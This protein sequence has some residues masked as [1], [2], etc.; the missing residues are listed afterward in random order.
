MKPLSEETE[1]RIQEMGKRLLEAARERKQAFWAREH[2]EEILFHK[3]MD[4]EQLRAQLLRFVDVLPALTSDEDLSKHLHEYLGEEDLPIPGF[5]KWG[6]EHSRGSVAAHLAAGAVRTA[7]HGLAKRFIGGESVNDA[8]NTVKHLR[9]ENMC[10]TLDLLGEATVSEAEADEY[11]D[12]Y[13]NFIKDLAPKLKAW[14]ANPLMDE[15]NGR[16]CPRFNLSIKVSSLCSQIDPIDIEGRAETIKKRLR[17]I[18]QAAKK[19]GAF[20][21]LDMEQYDMKE[22]ILRVFQDILVEP[23]FRDWPDVGIA[24][25]AYLRDTEKDLLGLIDWCR[26][27]GT[28]VTVRLVRGAYWDY[29]KIIAKQNE[30]NM[31]VWSEKWETD[32]CF[33]NCVRHLMDNYPALDIAVGYHNVRSLALAM[34]VAKEKGLQPGQFELQMLYGMADPLKEVI[35]EMNQRTRI[36]VPC[37]ELISVLPT[38]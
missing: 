3:L 32:I 20:I 9:K 36:Y 33:E 8:F 31:A 21:C 30:W 11:R 2:W 5:A 15:I 10:F 18:L 38:W 17:P 16:P 6:I 28:P 26:S 1:A 34:V 22:I 19:E 27:R 35:A 4:N 37:G 14:K 12:K 7:M 23:D 25:Q 24:L 13:L 29:E